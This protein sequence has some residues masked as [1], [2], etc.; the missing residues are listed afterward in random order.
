MNENGRTSIP[1]KRFDIWRRLYARFVLE[2]APASG[3][4]AAVG[5]EVVPITN[6][7][8]LLGE[9]RA[10][11]VVEDLTP[12]IG[13]YRGIYSVPAGKR[14]KLIALTRDQITGDTR[15]A[16]RLVTDGANV[17][18]FLTP[19]EA[20]FQ[21]WLGSPVTLNEGDSAGWLTS[22]NAGDG[23]RVGYAIVVEEDA[24]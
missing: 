22:G 3:S 20:P 13:A 6:V 12:T 16:I 8:E 4:A 10:F 23:A 9:P 14:A 21:S 24:F 17:D 19:L 7:D 18:V 1:S 15:L 2:P 5:T 11:R